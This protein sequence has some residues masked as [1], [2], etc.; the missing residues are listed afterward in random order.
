MNLHIR[1]AKASELPRVKEIC[2]DLLL[3]TKNRSV[4]SKA[5]ECWVVLDGTEIVAFG[6]LQPSIRFADVVYLNSAGV[7]EKY[8]GLGLQRR[9]IR[10]RL[11]WARRN[12]K[13]FAVTDTVPENAPSSRNL[14][15]CGFLPYT[16]EVPWKGPG[17]RYWSCKLD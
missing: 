8:R 12:K 4:W 11:A 14:V 15:R 5:C 3:D 2:D 9:L 16:P 17:A 6:S 1:K 13:H 7:C 10:V